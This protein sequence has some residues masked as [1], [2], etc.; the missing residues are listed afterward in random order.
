MTDKKPEQPAKEE[1][2]E[3]TYF[4][5]VGLIAFSVTGGTKEERSQK[6]DAM[7]AKIIELFQNEEG[8]ETGE[9]TSVQI[10]KLKKHPSGLYIPGTQPVVGANKKI[11]H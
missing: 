4:H 8:V 6:G 7:L 1:K 11:V 2:K 9:E 10:R 5:L 3:S